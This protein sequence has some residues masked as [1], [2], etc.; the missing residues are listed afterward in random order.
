MANASNTFNVVFHLRKVQTSAGLLP[1]Y[2]RITINTKRI[3]F[4]LKHQIQPSH[5]NEGR[6]MAKPIRD[7]YRNLNNYLE[8]MRS[9]LV[10]CYREMTL[11]KKVVDTKSFKEAYFGKEKEE[12]TLCKLVNYHNNDMKES[13]SWG[14]MK[15]Y[16]T[17]QKYLQ[18][19]MKQRLK[20]AD[21]PINE[22]TYRFVTEFEYYLKTYKPLDHHKPLNNNGV[23][24]HMERFRK[25]I[26]VALKNEWMVKDP[27]KAYKLKFTRYERGYLTREELT[28][29]ENK[30]FKLER[31]QVVKDLFVFACYT[32][33]AYIDAINLKP[34]NLI[35]GIDKEY[36]VMTERKK[37]STPVKV[38]LLPKAM[39]ILERYR[40]NA[41]CNAEGTL[42]PKMTNQK[43]N[44]YLKELADVCE[45]EKN[46]TFHLARH[47]FATTV[48]LS[49]GVPMESVS[50]MLGHT[51]ISTTQ[52][53]AKVVERKL[54]DDM[55]LLREKLQGNTP[56]KNEVQQNTSG[57]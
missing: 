39:E 9:S 19:F 14:T 38:P 48:T 55:K 52:V 56:D 46:F 30:D 18:I 29:L 40:N 5:W 37:T 27:F 4:S 21:I 31:M 25:M 17:T 35:I 33:F 45:I 8:Q 28:R 36:W 10:A 20:V 23:M 43:L 26:N 6:G 41:K 54:S 11:S 24:K 53:Y 42:L 16:H 1:I 3:E 15:N 22:I 34:E 7:E 57:M 50:K 44:S 13:L 49:N 51:K 47:T 12:F 32:G 2:A